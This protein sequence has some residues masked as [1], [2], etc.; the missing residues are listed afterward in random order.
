M[1]SASGFWQFVGGIGL[2]LFA[3]HQLEAALSAF[4]GGTLR[5]FL[6]HHTRT[7][8]QSVAV[9]ATATALLQSSSL[10]GLFV[11]AFVSASLMSLENALGVIFGANLGTT[12]T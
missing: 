11:L 5:K 6:R 1:S 12:I 9:G 3:M 8:L 10:V 4:T 7:G 2:F